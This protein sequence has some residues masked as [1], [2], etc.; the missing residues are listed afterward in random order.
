M[1]REDIM[2]KGIGINFIEKTKYQYAEPSEQERGLPQPPL[3]ESFNT[4][5]PSISLPEPS[6][7]NTPLKAVIDRRASLRSFHDEAISLAELSYLLWCTQG[8]R[9]RLPHATLR[10]VPSAGARH[11]F[12]TFILVN[13]VS[14][15]EVGVYRYLAGQHQV[16][17]F[18]PGVEIGR[19]IAEACLGQNFLREC[20]ATFIWTAVV[21]RM[22][23]RYTERGYRYLYLDAGHVCQNLYLAAE[24][25]GCG[26][27]AVGAFDDDAMNALLELDGIE[28]FV[29]YLAA[30][31][32]RSR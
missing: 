10:T 28:Q 32:K 13:R 2:A 30:T 5:Y 14:N 17:L 27:C 7:I 3:E 6:T 20:A 19:Q 11:A 23:Y 29:I 22:Y 1:N 26:A 18:I 9:D 25:I 12:E 31:G 24:S 4:A 15:L 21:K 16:K 8:I